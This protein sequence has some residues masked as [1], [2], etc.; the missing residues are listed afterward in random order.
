MNNAKIS[1]NK[2]AALCGV[3]QGT[4]DRA[5]NNRKGINPETKKRILAVAKEY[6]YRPNIHASSMAGGKSHLIGVVVFDLGNQYFSDILVSI[7]SYCASLG[8]STVVMFTDKDHEKETDC[9]RN[10][11]HMSVDG[12][13]LCP[14]NSGEEYERF[15]LSLNLPIITI[16]NK[17]SRIP[18]V[19]IDNALAVK[20][21]LE[22]V[23]KKGYQKLI[24]VKPPLRQRN[25]FAQTQ[26]LDAFITV[27]EKANVNYVITDLLNAEKELRANM[28][29]VLFCP[30]DIYAI[31]LLSAAKKYAA[32]IIGFDNIRL[33]D[34]LG[35]CLDS[36][37]YDVQLTAKTAVEH[38]VNG[39]AV[40][41]C[42]P[43]R[44]IKRG[45]A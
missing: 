18:Y 25:T 8:Y 43:H 33:I 36:V 6:G 4:V 28:P 15:L 5:L 45:S 24:Y 34:E 44:I 13:I 31:K 16:G 40:P 42:V 29:C 9:I 21:A 14:A 2:I 17:L 7:E 41:G 12:I 22:E 27:C 38:I 35:L 23:L 1:T 20:D 11:Y 30:T 10:L 3:S 26:R 32:G 39:A 37:A 19:G